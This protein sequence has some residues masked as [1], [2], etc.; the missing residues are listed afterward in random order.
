MKIGSNKACQL[1]PTALL[2]NLLTGDLG[3]VD[4]LECTEAFG[5]AALERSAENIIFRELLNYS[6][7]NSTQSHQ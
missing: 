6:E 2:H 4:V 3:V 5:L 7:S 1:S